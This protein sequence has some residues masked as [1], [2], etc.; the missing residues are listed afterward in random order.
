M[1]GSPGFPEGLSHLDEN[2]RNQTL[3]VRKEPGLHILHAAPSKPT[4]GKRQTALSKLFLTVTV[5]EKG[6]ESYL[7]HLLAF[8]PL[9]LS[10]PPTQRCFCALAANCGEQLHHQQPDTLRAEQKFISH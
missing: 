1:R 10:L 8:N 7:C 4:A 6:F 9:G 3:F 2:E 5:I